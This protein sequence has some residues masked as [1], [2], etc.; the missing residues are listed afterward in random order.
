MVA[1]RRMEPADLYRLTN[2]SDPQIS[3]DGELIAYVQTT[4]DP[5]SKE[6]SSSIWI[7]RTAGGTPVPFTSGKKDRAPRWSPDGNWLCFS[8]ARDGA[9]Q[10][11]LISRHGGEAQALTELKYG[12]GGAHWAPDSKRIAFSSDVDRKAERSVLLKKADEADKKAAEK[13]AKDEA[14]V[15]TKMEWRSDSAGILEERESQIWVVDLPKPGATTKPTPMQI[16]WGEFEHGG[17]AWSP[18]GKQIAFYAKRDADE[19]EW[20]SDVWV[21]SV[22]ETRMRPPSSRS[23]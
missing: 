11:Y 19:R 17:P 13:K 8:S 18:D 10:L 9:P 16:T 14:R 3:P 20:Y 7:A 21:T 23:S 12:A 5:E 2:V 22:P 1:K 4:I 6:S 15:F